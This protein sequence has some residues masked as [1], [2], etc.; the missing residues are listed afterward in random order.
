MTKYCK[1]CQHPIYH[2]YRFAEFEL[3]S[4]FVD[5]DPNSDTFNDEITQ[6]PSCGQ[7]LAVDVLSEE[8]RSEAE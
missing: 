6:C 1:K 4:V 5:D 8:V 2:Y 3:V 7:W